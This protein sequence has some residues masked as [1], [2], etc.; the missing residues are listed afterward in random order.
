MKTVKISSFLFGIVF[1]VA[2]QDDPE[3]PSLI[4]P[5]TYDF[6]RNGQS[7]VS[8]S[9]QTD[10]LNQLSE[11]KDYLSKGNKKEVIIDA[12]KLNAMFA[13]TNGNGGGHFSFTS[14]RKLKDKTFAP[15][16]AHFES[17][18][19]KM[20]DASFAAAP[21]SDGIAGFIARGSSTILVDENGHEYAQ[22]I[23]KGLMGSVFLN[24][25]YNVYLTDERVGDEIE[26][27][28]LD[29]SNNYTKMEHH[30]DEAFGYFGV[31]VDFPAT[32]TNRFW[33]NYSNGRDALLNT[34]SLLMD[35]FKTGRAAIVAKRY[36]IK[37][38]QRE[39]LYDGFELLAASTAIHYLNDAKE[40]L[41][42]DNLGEAFHSLSEAYAFTQALRLSPKKK[43]TESQI[44]QILTVNIGE[45][46]WDLAQTDLSGINQA[47][48]TLTSVYPELAPVKD[49]L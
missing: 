38:E 43:I 35:A 11:I 21:A 46:F 4:V 9:G 18:F 10:R 40:F 12:N 32:T 47:I 7:S 14:D 26:N 37:N 44:T 28:A 25:I 17:Q 24:Q 36:D 30:W 42:A 34:N 16:V 33:G 29:G 22:I 48:S 6:Q 39:I 15:D 13:N 5:Q 45:N 23:E 3:T 49:S 8:Y 27:T 1:L 41:A 20:A 2:C 19:E 31:P